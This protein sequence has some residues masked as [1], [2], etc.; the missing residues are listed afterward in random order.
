MDSSTEQAASCPAGVDPSSGSVP[1]AGPSQLE[2]PNTLIDAGPM[3]M[4][5]FRVEFPRTAPPVTAPPDRSTRRSPSP[6]DD[7]LTAKKRGVRPAWNQYNHGK[8]ART[9]DMVSSMLRD[10]SLLVLRNICR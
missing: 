8:V 3:P 6:P 9:E 7:S 4:F 5:A 1:D 2:P 10:C